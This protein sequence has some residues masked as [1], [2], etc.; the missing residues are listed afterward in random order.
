MAANREKTRLLDGL[1]GVSALIGITLGVIPL[2]GWALGAQSGGL[3]ER[4]FG[5]SPSTSLAYVL[6]VV[7]IV[8][9]IGLIA[10][11]EAMKRA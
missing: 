11:L 2:T 4:I 3:L 8:L 9:V 6:P 1:Q 5:W 7:V 10:I